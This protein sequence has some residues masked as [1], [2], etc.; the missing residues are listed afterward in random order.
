M[1]D[2]WV[3]LLFGLQVQHAQANSSS[4]SLTRMKEGG[5]PLP[6]ASLLIASGICTARGMVAHSSQKQSIAVIGEFPTKLS[7][8]YLGEHLTQPHPQCWDLIA[9]LA[10]SV[11]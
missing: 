3:P 5:F 1:E 9:V 11:V 2:A 7:T 8:I 4:V 10:S 6:F